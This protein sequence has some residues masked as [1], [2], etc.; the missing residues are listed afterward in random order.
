MGTGFS[1]GWI[2]TGVV[3]VE[4]YEVPEPMWIEEC[5]GSRRN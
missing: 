2:T 3:N 5:H 1:T 4:T